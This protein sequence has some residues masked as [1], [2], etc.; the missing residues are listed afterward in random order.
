MNALTRK[1]VAA[2]TI[3]SLA[4]GLA[5]APAPA[6]NFNSTG[7]QNEMQIAFA[8]Y[9]RTETLTNFPALVVLSP[10]I[11]NFQ[12]SQFLSGTNADLVF[13]DGTQT[14]MLNYEVE[15]WNTNGSSYV[16]VQVPA[17]SSNASVWAF[18]GKNGQTAPACTTNGATWSGSFAGVWHMKE[19]TG[20]KV[21]DSASTNNGTL[22][23]SPTWTNGLVDGA[24]SFNGVNQYAT[25]S[26]SPA[27][28]PTFPFTVSVVA[29]SDLTTN[30]TLVAD[31]DIGGNGGYAGFSVVLNTDG[32]IA[33][34]VGPNA[35]YGGPTFRKTFITSANAVSSNAWHNI[36]VVFNNINSFP[37]YV[38]GSP[39][40]TNSS[41]S[42]GSLAYAANNQFR[43]SAI[44]D[45]NG[46]AT[47]YYKTQMDDV[48]LSTVSRSSN[49]IWAAYQN[50]ASNAVFNTYTNVMPITGSPTLI[51]QPATGIADLYASL[52]G[53]L[54]STGGSAT[55]VSVYWGLTDGSNNA[56]NWSNTNIFGTV[57]ATCPVVLT[58]NITG[59]SASTTYCYRYFAT[60]DAGGVW[61]APQSFTTLA[62]LIA[63]AV[64][65]NAGATRGPLF[66]AS[67]RGQVTAGNPSPLTYVCWGTANGGTTSTSGWQYVD[68]LG[69]QAAGFADPVSGLT[70]NTV[71]YYACFATNAV[72][73]GWSAVT[74]FIAG[75]NVIWTGSGG[76]S[77]WN[78]G[79]N[80]SGGTVPGPS[81]STVFTNLGLTAGKVISLDASQTVYGVTI[82]TTTSFTIG[83]TNDMI[84]VTNTLALVNVNRVDVT[85]TEGTH[86]LLARVTLATNSTWTVNGSAA[87]LVTNKISGGTFSL[88]KNGAGELDMAVANSYGT[89][90]LRAGSIIHKA[91]VQIIPG[92]LYVGGTNTAAVFDWSGTT[93]G[94][95]LNPGYSIYALTNGTIYLGNAQYVLNWNTYAGGTIVNLYSYV[96]YGNIYM[97]GGTING[98]GNTY[99]ILY[100][101]YS[102]A[103][104]STA[105]ISVPPT[106]WIYGSATNYV[107]SGSAPIGLKIAA[108]F[109]GGTVGSSFTKTGAGVLQV[110]GGSYYAYTNTFINGGTWLADNPSGSA[111]STSAVTVAVGATL[112]GKGTVAGTLANASVTLA[113]GT[114]TNSMATLAPGSI[115]GNSGNHILG[116]LT[117]GTVPQS[118]TVT[119]G[120]FTRLSVNLGATPTN[121]D[122]L[123]VNG[124]LY[125]GAASNTNYLDIATTNLALKSG[126]YTLASFNV[127]TGRFTTVRAT[128]PGR[129]N[130]KYL[131]TPSGTYLLNGSIVV[132]VPGQGTALI[133]E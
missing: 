75:T 83:S 22:F 14:N 119:F 128:L 19:G 91:N 28:R 85:G 93:D 118:N 90:Y 125:L 100:G 114:T 11:G 36:T 127:L 48:Q 21:A 94:S 9:N 66:T 45:P 64:N 5:V 81:D 54:T 32:S 96:N 20:T 86:T 16:W 10:N 17:L 24:L 89:T 68:G 15:T 53:T 71:Y 74:N 122:C 107:E 115:D 76:N 106:L 38:D 47:R 34:Q 59:L 102:Y 2:L 23:N 33:A 129:Y 133:F 42:A 104:N 37:I 25:M 112:G 82:A 6:A 78:N 18:W 30:P 52:N 70:S 7:W 98:N 35:G 26:N 132:T 120:K 111:T 79:G 43:L 51:V 130:V 84:G 73:S 88:T 131:G 113:S 126:D 1:Q 92:N 13:T 116:T 58:T 87:L 72:G 31:C 55:A 77:S 49:W 27:L 69:T 108:G 110:T 40:A 8:G 123:A 99:G 39:Q 109:T 12:Y 97:T 29:K 44:Y 105:L 4:L 62:L 121:C 41:G 61:S 80:W 117:I 95:V 103:T 46:P 67:L 50:E 3:G 63:P 57:T 60:N 65:N 56:A 124:T 101:I